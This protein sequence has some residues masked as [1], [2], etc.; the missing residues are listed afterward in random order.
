MSQLGG[1][2]HHLGAGACGQDGGAAPDVA[3]TRAGRTPRR[4]CQRDRR[5]VR[6]KED[7]VTD[8]DDRRDKRQRD[9][10]EGVRL[11]GA[12]EA[13][14]ALERDD[15]RHRFAEGRP[16]FG[17]RP[18]AARRGAPPGAALPARVLRRPQLDRAA[19]GRA[20]PA[21][22][23]GAR[24]V[25]LGRFGRR[26]GPAH[27]RPR[28][29]P[30]RRDLVGRTTPTPGGGTSRRRRPAPGRSR[31]GPPGG[32]PS[33]RGRRTRGAVEP[34]S[35]G[36]PRAGAVGL[37]QRRRPAGQPS[38]ER[39]LR[40]RPA[41]ATRLRGRVHRRRT[42]TST[43]TRSTTSRPP[44]SPTPGARGGPPVGTAPRRCDSP[45]PRPRP[46]HGRARGRRCSSAA[47]LA[48]F[49]VLGPLGGMIVAVPVLAYAA[50]RVLRGRQHGRLR[51]ADAGGRGGH[52]RRVIAAYNYGEARA[53]RSCWCCRW[54]CASSG[55]WSAPVATVPWPTSA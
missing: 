28:P 43:T 16:R 27:E 29:A 7:D 33:R 38:Y 9:P 36:R 13:A 39:A 10:T 34:T 1:V 45:G 40:R 21:P 47:A 31:A 51:G 12:D 8:R 54:P 49:K 35:A 46:A 50:V 30:G 5:R 23:R 15:I 37:R 17:D 55:T 14:E 11:L 6:R 52:R 4:T 25:A 22:D 3:A 44:A 32:R 42:T 41:T 2:C 53:S 20:R 24:A 18:V 48:L 26:G 19:A